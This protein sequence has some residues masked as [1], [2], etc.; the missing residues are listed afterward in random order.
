ME[1]EWIQPELWDLSP[2]T[3]IDY[4]WLELRKQRERHDRMRKRLFAEL[5]NLKKENAD[6]YDSIRELRHGD[7]KGFNFG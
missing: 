5:G 3:E 6:L 7:A 4:L 1:T 2:Q